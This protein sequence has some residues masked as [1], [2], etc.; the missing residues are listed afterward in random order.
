MKSSY[1]VD[2]IRTETISIVR[3]REK[4]GQNKDTDRGTRMMKE[5]DTDIPAE[6]GLVMY[7]NKISR[8]E[9]AERKMKRKDCGKARRLE[10]FRPSIRINRNVAR[11]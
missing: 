2:G 3:S 5:T 6:E 10:Y 8:E 4:N 7:W 9:T 11:R 1:L